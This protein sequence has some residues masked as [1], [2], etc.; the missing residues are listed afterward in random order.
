VIGKNPQRRRF[1]KKE[2]SNFLKQFEHMMWQLSNENE[3]EL[4]EQSI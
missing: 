3:I 4:S 1:D 2:P